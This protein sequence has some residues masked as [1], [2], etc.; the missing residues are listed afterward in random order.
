MTET[1]ADLESVASSVSLGSVGKVMV[2]VPVKE[3]ESMVTDSCCERVKDSVSSSVGVLNVTDSCCEYVR[4]AVCD[5]VPVSDP[6]PGLKEMDAECETLLVSVTLLLAVW[7]CSSVPV[8][9]GV[10]VLLDVSGELGLLDPVR[11]GEN[12]MSVFDSVGD[13]V[14]V[15]VREPEAVAV[16]LLDSDTDFVTVG[17]SV[18]VGVPVARCGDS[19]RVV[20]TELRFVCEAVLEG[21]CVSV[22]V[23]TPPAVV[24]STRSTSRSSRGM[25][26]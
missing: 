13:S 11:W 6:V 10:A 17:S 4:L 3:N 15:C 24:T 19:V 20:E 2:R 25:C 16:A 9:V 18:T 12:V 26:V 21:E 8:M 22:S 14:P 1:V 5:V 7:D 23:A